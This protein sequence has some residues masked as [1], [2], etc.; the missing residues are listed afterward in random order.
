MAWRA[1]GCV[2]GL[3]RTQATNPVPCLPAFSVTFGWKGC[4]VHHR[5]PSWGP[6][7][8]ASASDGGPQGPVSCLMVALYTQGQVVDGRGSCSSVWI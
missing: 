4:T 1:G 5:G 6:G 3:P 7:Q 8:R 2:L